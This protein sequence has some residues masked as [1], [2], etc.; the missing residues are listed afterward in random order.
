MVTCLECQITKSCQILLDF[1]LK[2]SRISIRYKKMGLKVTGG[3][4]SEFVTA[5]TVE[6]EEA[7]FV[8]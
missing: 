5:G 7:A 6:S 1:S 8:K 2:K 3:E 4:Q